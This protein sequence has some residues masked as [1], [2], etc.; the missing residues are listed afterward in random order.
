MGGRLAD[1][2]LNDKI[3]L[4]S[5]QGITWTVGDSTIAQSPYMPAFYGAQAFVESM[6]MTQSN[7][8][9]RRVPSAITTWSCPFIYLF[10]GFNDQNQLL[11]NVWR[12][13]Y[14]RMTNYPV[15]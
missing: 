6:D 4:S 12:G 7:G 13:V 3:Y 15:Y 2:T 11:P 9:P 5:T 14:I 10:G 1:G 8:A